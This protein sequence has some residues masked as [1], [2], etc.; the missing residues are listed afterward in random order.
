M[1]A[2]GSKG[3]ALQAENGWDVVGGRRKATKSAERPIL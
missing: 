1:E 3:V 2:G